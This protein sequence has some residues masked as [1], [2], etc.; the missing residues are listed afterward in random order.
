MA[1]L[2]PV[3]DNLSAVGL[4]KDVPSYRAPPEAFTT[5][6]NMR[7]VEQK[8]QRVLGRVTQPLGTPTVAPYFLFPIRNSAE[9]LF[10]VYSS[11]LKC[12]VVSAGVHSDITRAA[13]GDYNATGAK[14]WNGTIHGGIPILNTGNDGL[15][16]WATISAA[17]RLTALANWPA[18]NRTKLIRSLWPHMVALN[19]QL[20]GVSLPNAVLWSHPSDPGAV[21]S[22]WDYTNPAVDAGIWELPDSQQGV[23]LEARA[24]RGQ[25]FIYK[26]QATWTMRFIGGRPVMAFNGFLETTGT[27]G[28]RCVAPTGDGKWHFVVTQDDIFI[29]NGADIVPLLES[30]MRKTLFNNIDSATYKT[31]FV[32]CNPLYKEMWFCYPEPGQ[33]AP[34]RALVWNYGVKS[35][36]G[37]FSEVAVDFQHAAVGDTEV[38]GYAWSAATQLWQDSADPWSQS[39]RGQVLTA[40]ASN[41]KII[42]LDSGA[43]Y[44]GAAYTSTLAREATGFIGRK[45]DGTPTV[46]F[47]MVKWV[48]RLWIEALGGPIMVRIGSQ[49]TT[50]GSVTWS[51]AQSFDPSTQNYLDFAHSPGV[52][53]SI[54]F[55]ATANFDLVSYKMEIV[56]AGKIL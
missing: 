14:D 23:I 13:G 42:Q 29:H 11:L 54:E 34:S 12:Y 19:I 16:N 51:A 26:E 8:A 53:L 2:E 31:S 38:A 17:T 41:T 10:W 9:T 55:T 52:A 28:T 27:L 49:N 50:T 39:N 18:A 5:A 1:V 24:L 47:S 30:R 22:S 46:D 44:D 45:P 32:F 15:Q 48:R 35:S 3:V 25:L 40:K 43:T 37:A 4:V 7:F 20:A 6:L 36:I 33:S 56:K 21:P